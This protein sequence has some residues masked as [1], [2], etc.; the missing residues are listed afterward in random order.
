MPLESLLKGFIGY[1]TIVGAVCM[2][3]FF[4]TKWAA[5]KFFD[6]DEF[7]AF[8]KGINVAIGIMVV[9]MAFIGGKMLGWW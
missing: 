4:I 9:G 3:A 1:A 8:E 5:E 2:A 7:E 6:Y